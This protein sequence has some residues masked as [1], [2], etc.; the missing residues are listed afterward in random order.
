MIKP[1]EGSVDRAVRI[2]VGLVALFL[3]YS[4]LTGVVQIIAYIIGVIALITGIVGFCG[5]YAVLGINT[6]PKKK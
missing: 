1:N 5:L 3:A 2:V 4:S 6:L